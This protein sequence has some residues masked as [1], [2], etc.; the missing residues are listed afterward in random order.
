VTTCPLSRSDWLLRVRLKPDTTSNRALDVIGAYAITPSNDR[1]S[2]R[3]SR[4]FG[5]ERLRRLLDEGFWT[6]N[7]MR[8]PP[9]LTGNG[10]NRYALTTVNIRLETE[11]PSPRPR[12]AVIVNCGD[13]ASE[14]NV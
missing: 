13:C 14:R 1:K 9:S 11:S 10:R 8:L 2:S 3:I 7:A 6:A 12:T 4:R 5:Y